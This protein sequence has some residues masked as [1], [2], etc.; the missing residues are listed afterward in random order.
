[1]AWIGTK[2]SN[3]DSKPQRLASLEKWRKWTSKRTNEQ[4]IHTNAKQ[5][6]GKAQWEQV[7]SDWIDVLNAESSPQIERWHRPSYGA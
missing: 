7:K 5:D 1:M 2:A 3:H 6:G 4:W